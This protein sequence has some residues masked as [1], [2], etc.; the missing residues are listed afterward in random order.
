MNA[1]ADHARLAR[2]LRDP[3]CWPERPASVDTLETHISIVY[4]V[5]EHA[6]KLK[7]PVD[8][9]FLDF[10][11]ME[12]RR[13][14]CAEEVRLNRRLAPEIYLRA[15]PIGGTLDH[16]I[17]DGPSP[18]IDWLVQMRRFSSPQVLA[19]RTDQLKPPLIQSLAQT[20]AAFHADAEQ[21]G[22][23]TD[24]G[25]P[26]AV[27]EPMRENFAQL[28]RRTKEPAILSQ[29]EPLEHW[30]EHN[31][32]RLWPLLE[33]R[34]AQ[35]R[36]RECHGDLHLGNIVLEQ[37]RPIIFDGIEFSPSLRWIDCLSDLAFL[38]ADLCH[39]GHA[40]L[41]NLA[42]DH[43]LEQTGDYPGL[44]LLPLYLVYRAMVR[45]KVTAIRLEQPGLT[46]DER[47]RVHDNCLDYL[48]RASRFSQPQ[49]TALIITHGLS[50]SGKS[51][52]SRQLVAQLPN[53]LRVSSDV[54]RKRLAGLEPLARTGAGL[55][56][57]I[58][59]RAMSE[60]TYQRLLDCAEAILA[61]GRSALID[62]T[63][64]RQSQRHAFATLAE[65]LGVPFY[66]LD[67]E[68][69]EKELRLRIERRAA[70][71]DDPSDAGLAVLA[72]Q[73]ASQEPLTPAERACCPRREPFEALV[74]LL[75][76]PSDR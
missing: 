1:L 41:A 49:P 57:G 60:H 56:Q 68:V 27:L 35:G 66:I 70:R 18:A 8:L 31:A 75:D 12:K 40:E 26:R 3:A 6:Y 15:L 63:F 55:D 19:D 14:Y 2:A 72:A 16:P 25:T 61:A 51:H 9:G 62:A 65:R 32:Q 23:D 74:N 29:L 67:F 5:G 43:Y 36:I 59:R 24:F 30:L 37:G 17:P 52:L 53:C 44:P 33:Q 45:A 54:E 28:R 73:I 58:Y 48:R 20:I 46:E 22:S 34:R 21:A 47:Q 50:G 10:S 42:L 13:H 39:Q 38:L 71:N 4:L 69:P 11:S 64:L 76:R 7:K